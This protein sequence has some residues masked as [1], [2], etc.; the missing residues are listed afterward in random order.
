MVEHKENYFL[1]M[2]ENVNDFELISGCVEFHFDKNE[3]QIT[4][5]K[6][7]D[8]YGNGWVQSREI[9]NSEYFDYT[10][11]YK[12][13]FYDMLPGEQRFIYIPA[14]C[15]RDVFSVINTRG[16]LKIDNCNGFVPEDSKLDGTNEEIYDSKMFTLK[17]IVSN[18]P[19]DPNFMVTDPQCLEQE[20]G[21]Q[22]VKYKIYFQNDG[23][24]PVED[25]LIDLYTSGDINYDNVRLSSSSHNC[26]LSWEEEAFYISFPDIFL[27]GMGAEPEPNTYEETIGWVELEICF[28]LISSIND[29]L[30]CINSFGQIIFDD[31]PPLP[32]SNSLCTSTFCQGNVDIIGAD[33]PQSE[34][35]Q[36]FS[37]SG[38]K[39][40]K[41]NEVSKEID[42]QIIPNFSKSK[43]TIEGINDYSNLNCLIVNSIGGLVDEINLLK[44]NEIN[45]SNL[46]K[47]IY[48]I[49]VFNNT[50]SQIK[51]FVKI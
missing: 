15:L 8:S 34:I 25:V 41:I 37:G 46:Q 12:W 1:L 3:I 16:I 35:Y 18:Y 43:I 5:D 19:H 21:A 17:S 31:Q 22:K 42:F 11:K 29:Q 10:N 4:E 36:Q 45:I 7:L 33:C 23:V 13:E 50:N 24:D 14:E 26:N 6:I 30:D 27:K 39:T 32:I 40:V 38:L 47:G 9:E 51:K 28:N 44:I 48:Y 20:W 2:F 49:K